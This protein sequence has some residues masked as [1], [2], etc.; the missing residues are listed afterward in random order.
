MPPLCTRCAPA[1]PPLAPPCVGPRCAPAPAVPPLC[2]RCAPAGPP[3]GPRWAPVGPRWAPS[4]SHPPSNGK[5][6]RLEEEEGLRVLAGY[7][8]TEAAEQLFGGEDLEELKEELEAMS[9]EQLREGMEEME[10]ATD[11]TEEELIARI[12]E[13]TQQNVAID[14][15]AL[16]DE[17]KANDAKFRGSMET[18]DAAVNASADAVA[19]NQTNIA[20]A[21]KEV[22]PRVEQVE[23]AQAADHWTAE[24]QLNVR[25][26][27]SPTS[28]KRVCGRSYRSSCNILLPNW[29]ISC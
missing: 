17:V 8:G 12:I 13:A 23:M 16:R 25:V 1:V 29:S 2:P 28:Q 5:R 18:I 14:G 20:V 22:Q 21:V 6:A 27:P 19:N 26:H 4:G 24:Q 9:V 7:M 11:G 3:L 10:L 15:T